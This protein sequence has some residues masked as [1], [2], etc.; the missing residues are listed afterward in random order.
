MW[1]GIAHGMLLLLDLKNSTINKCPLDYISL[2]RDTLDNFAALELAPE[3]GE[4]L[5]LDEVPDI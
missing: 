2:R 1:D 3:G 4:V 5:E